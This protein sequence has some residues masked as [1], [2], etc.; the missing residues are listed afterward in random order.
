MEALDGSG[1]RL[2]EEH[3]VEAPSAPW[4]RVD[5]AGVEHADEL[6]A[7]EGLDHR[8]K[9]GEIL[10]GPRFEEAREVFDP[11]TVVATAGND[12]ARDDASVDGGVTRGG[13]GAGGSTAGVG[14]GLAP[15][16]TLG[17]VE[18]AFSFSTVNCGLIE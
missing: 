7:V 10:A 15:K 6:L 13:T 8:A 16:S 11:A 9:V 18:M 17:A 2:G 3:R 12:R 5:V 14:A 1:R 4:W